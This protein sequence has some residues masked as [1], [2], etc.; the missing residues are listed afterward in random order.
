MAF[1]LDDD[2]V[3]TLRVRNTLILNNS[4]EMLIFLLQ[5]INSFSMI[6]FIYTVSA[7]IKRS[8]S[9]ARHPFIPK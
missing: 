8:I 4:G 9:H 1:E 6:T 7:Y 3:H 5:S 2:I